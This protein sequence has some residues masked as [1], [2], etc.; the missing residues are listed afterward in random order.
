MGDDVDPPATDREAFAVRSQLVHEWRK[1]LFTD[2][3]LPRDLLPE[4]WAGETAAEFFDRHATRLQ[5]GAAR[6][7]DACLRR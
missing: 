7:V 6:W 2:P 1:F 4:D 5:P 3:G